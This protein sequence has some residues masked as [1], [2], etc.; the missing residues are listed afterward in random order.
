VV[1]ACFVFVIARTCGCHMTAAGLP[2]NT[3]MVAHQLR[4][5]T[6]GSR[7]AAG[8]GWRGR[9]Q[10]SRQLSG[11][12]GLPHRSSQPCSPGDAV[13]PVPC[14]APWR[15]AGM[16]STEPQQPQNSLV[17]GPPSAGSLSA[18]SPRSQP[19]KSDGSASDTAADVEHRS[20]SQQHR[21]LRPVRAPAASDGLKHDKAVTPPKLRA[22]PRQPPSQRIPGVGRRSHARSQRAGAGNGNSEEGHSGDQRDQLLKS[23]VPE[24]S[25][26]LHVDHSGAAN[27][28]NVGSHGQSH[29]DTGGTHTQAICLPPCVALG[30]EKL[31]PVQWA[32]LGLPLNTL[33]APMGLTGGPIRAA[34]TGNGPRQPLTTTSLAD[35]LLP[36][37]NW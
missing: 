31:D 1:S 9:R 32:A 3:N 33:G 19:S 12:N 6:G 14:P 23:S 20:E 15:T 26:P 27:V 2:F 35:S 4:V 7:A 29:G 10:P 25:Q 37:P 17:L 36:P 30:Y 34:A 5:G 11:S 16:L 22:S 18:A 24:A 21:H 13:I 28:D 8:S